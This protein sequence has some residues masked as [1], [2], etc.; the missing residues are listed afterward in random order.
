MEA[1]RPFYSSYF[2]VALSPS[3]SAVRRRDAVLAEAGFP[4]HRHGNYE[5]LRPMGCV[6][7]KNKKRRSLLF[8]ETDDPGKLPDDKAVE[9]GKKEGPLHRNETVDLDVVKSQSPAISGNRRSLQKMAPYSRPVTSRCYV[10]TFRTICDS[11]REVISEEV[12][13][14][15]RTINIHQFLFFPAFQ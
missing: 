6:L 2:S 5:C 14:S 12:E 1:L 7:K 15:L 9:N 4:I 11:F 10:S 8:K 13:N 3:G